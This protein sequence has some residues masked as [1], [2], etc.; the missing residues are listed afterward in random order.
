MASGGPRKPQKPAPV[1]GPGKFAQRTDGGVNQPVRKMTGGEYGDN[2]ELATLQGSAPMNASGRMPQ[3]E[4]EQA[5]PPQASPVPFDAPSGRPDE[6]VTA[7]NP[8]GPGAGP[9]PLGAPLSAARLSETL[10]SVA[11]A[12]G[13]GSLDDLIVAMEEAGL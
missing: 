11:A 4:M 6:P 13:D 9:S 2:Q 3:G 5:P 10:R 8:F 12:N 1:S 7:G